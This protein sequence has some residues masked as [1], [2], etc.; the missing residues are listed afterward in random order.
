MSAAR[1]RAA[2]LAGAIAALLAL[3]AGGAA[4]AV[5]QPCGGVPQ[6]A[7]PTGDGHHSATDVLGAWFS[8]ESGGLQAVIRVKAGSWQ[9]EHDDAEL[10]GSGFALVFELGGASRYVRAR[11]WPGGKPVEF[12]YGTYAPGSW[13]TSAGPTTGAVVPAAFGGTATIDLPPAL[14]AVPGSVL[15][16]PFVLTYDGITAGEPDWVDQAPGGSPPNDPARGADYVVGSCGAA[17]GGIAAIQLGAPRRIVGAGKVTVSGRVL[18]A[19]AG[20]AVEL[21]RRGIGSQT[22]VLW[23]DA[24][25]RFGARLPIREATELRAVAEGIG[26]QAVRIAMGSRVKI[27]LQRLHSGA[28]RIR[29]RTDPGL[30]GRLLLLG[31]NDVAP[32]RTKRIGGARFALRL[33]A[34]LVPGSYQAVYVPA[35]GRAERSTSNTVRVR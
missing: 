21:T 14:G 2:L 27:R 11:A 5:P 19:R 17:G 28:L 8:E 16:R 12:D 24:A 32:L 10:N 34:G 31:V 3:G 13:F 29:G 4:A 26:S 9:P 1:R 30:P 7:D 25:G 20:V 23:T 33:P 6:I 15:A 35:K 18:P 22:S